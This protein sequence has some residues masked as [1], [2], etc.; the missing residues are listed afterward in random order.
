M[1]DSGLRREVQAIAFLLLA[2]FLAGALMLRGWT[3]LHHVATASGSF[4]WVGS[5]VAW[6]LITVFGWTGAA[7]LPIALGVHALRVFGRL[8]GGKDRSWLIFL[9]GM[10]LVLPF[11]VAL[12]M[13]AT[14]ESNVFSGI[15]GGLI[16]FYTTMLTGPV[17][18]WLIFVLALSVLAA[19][20]LSW[21]PIRMLVGREIVPVA[22]PELAAALDDTYKPPRVRKQKLL[23]Q[24]LEPDPDEMPQIDESLSAPFE[25]KKDKTRHRRG[26]EERVTAAIEATDVS[27][28]RFD[29]A[30]L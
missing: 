20:T 9:L 23:A 3:E 25:L 17:G 13:G 8:S 26:R 28:E 4:G 1:R 24:Q 5:H 22:N 29:D 10:V 12:A 2:V 30:D 21:N 6:A 7:L 15:I 11:G 16:A 14:R 19:A 18:A 27:H